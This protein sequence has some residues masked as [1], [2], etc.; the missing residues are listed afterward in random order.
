M[1]W[2]VR[3]VEVTGSTNADLLEAARGGEAGPTV[4]AARAQTAGRGRLGRGWQSAPGTSLSVSVLLT[5]A[6]PQAA[7]TW[8]PVVVGLGVLDALAGLGAR[9]GTGSGAV[10]LKWPNDVVVTDGPGAELGAGPGPVDGARTGLAKLA[11]ILAET[12]GTPAGPAV[13][14]GVGV[15]LADPDPVPPGGRATSLQRLLD[16]PVGADELLPLLEEGLRG[17]VGAWERAGG[18]AAASGTDAAYRAVCT[19]LGRRVRASTPGG[20]REGTAVDLARDGSLVLDGPG[21]RTTV[22][23]GDVEHLR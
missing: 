14:V 11:G 3:V 20:V 13:V 5:P 1:V 10:G 16:R 23:A 22:S 12:T 17:R 8:L 15:N 4:L 21:G 7:W 2:P 6:V 19:T 18:D 9:P